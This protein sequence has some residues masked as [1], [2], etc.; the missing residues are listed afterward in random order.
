MNL[1]FENWIHE[2]KI[3][4]ESLILFDESIMC[5]RVGAYRASFLMSYLGFMKALRD[6]LLKS[7]KPSLVNEHDWE[8][9]RNDLRDDKIWEDIVLKTIQE[10]EKKKAGSKEIPRSKVFLISND[11]IEEIPY[12]RKK[13][14]ECAHAKETII[15]H[16]HVETFWLFLQSNLSKFVVNGGKDALLNKIEKHF[17]KKYTEPNSD[18]M[19]LINQIPLV[20]KSHEIPFLLKTLLD[21]YVELYDAPKKQQYLFW[22]SIAY[23]PDKKLYSGFLE[24]MKLDNDIFC[25][26]IS[27]FP[28]KLVEFI[29]ETSL[30]RLF[31]TDL[32]FKKIGPYSDNLWKLVH[33]LLVHNKIPT[34][35]I[36]EFIEKISR[37]LGSWGMPDDEQTIV[38]KKHGIFSILREKIFESGVL[39]RNGGY[40][41]ANNNANKI[42]FYLK[43]NSL[44]TLIVEELNEFFMGYRFGGFNPLM[45]SYIQDNPN[46]INL[47]REIA[48]KNDITLCNFFKEESEKEVSEI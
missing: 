18:F 6:R 37:Y 11:L 43:N 45:Q 10:K 47:F 30:I 8:K 1:H 20:V 26:F 38:L 27:V 44:D 24:F 46:F 36:D 28:D 40:S 9:V 29:E 41:Y 19:H 33:T 21:D 22:K 13:R 23:T 32:L 7:D 4:E 17:D 15:E 31:W 3:S 39:N 25:E 12:W 2:Q 5:Y 48:S 42:M 14:N 35:E 34:L 16:S